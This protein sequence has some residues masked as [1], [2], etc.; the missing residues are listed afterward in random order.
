MW[1]T[2][3]NRFIIEPSSESFFIAICKYC[4]DDMCVI[5]R[6]S[7]AHIRISFIILTYYTMFIV[8]IALYIYN[9]DYKY[10]LIKKIKIKITNLL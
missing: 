10:I 6:L 3:K 2:T 1:F 7:R 5:H 9:L 4:S 8:C